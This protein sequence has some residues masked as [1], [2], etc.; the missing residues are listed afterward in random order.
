VISD[1]AIIYFHSAGFL[2]PVCH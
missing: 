2:C 1:M